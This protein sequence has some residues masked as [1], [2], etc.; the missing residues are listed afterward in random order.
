MS[1][2]LL[3]GDGVDQAKGDG[4]ALGEGAEVKVIAPAGKGLPEPWES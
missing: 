1:L 2:G 3:L 4:L